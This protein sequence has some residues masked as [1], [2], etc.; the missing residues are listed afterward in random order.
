MLSKVREV[1]T[2]EYREETNYRELAFQ[3]LQ[4]F[5]LKNTSESV[6]DKIKRLSDKNFVS[7]FKV[8]VGEY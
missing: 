6:E 8:D 4:N 3:M 2:K 1:F 5:R 7:E